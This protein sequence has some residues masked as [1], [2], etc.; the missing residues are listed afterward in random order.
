MG[1]DQIFDEIRM[2]DGVG[3]TPSQIEYTNYTLFFSEA[4]LENGTLTAKV[5]MVKR[6]INE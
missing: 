6:I 2:V 1:L 4:S 5:T 3:Y